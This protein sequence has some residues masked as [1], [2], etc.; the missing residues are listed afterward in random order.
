MSRK[1]ARWVALVIVGVLLLAYPASRLVR[2][3]TM[4]RGG[5]ATFTRLIGSANAQDVETVRSLCSS[6][7]LASH[8]IERSLEGGVV[9]FPRNIHRNFQVWTE[10]DEVWLCPG[11]RVGAVYRMVRE[12]HLWKFDGLV[13]LLK[14]GGRVELSERDSEP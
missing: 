8:A 10:G 1:T 11:N 2:S 9:G 13:G 5:M 4:T 6:R 7:Y 12:D 3:L 14:A